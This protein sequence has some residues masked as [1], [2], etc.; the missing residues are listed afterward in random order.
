MSEHRQ[1]RCIEPPRRVTGG[2]RHEL[3]VKAELIQE[4]TQPR[5]IMGGETVMRAEW[6]G[7]FGER[8]AK[9][10]RHHILVRHVVW[11]FAQPVHVVGERDQ[12]CLYL[13]IGEDTKGMAHHGGARDFAECTDM[14][15]AGGAVAGLE[16]QLVFRLLLQARN[17]LARLLERP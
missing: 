12:P 7:Y 9:M 1:Q 11:D 10:P 14:R 6:V 3:V 4:S 15:Q 13:V 16:D 17:E 2:C 5:I 8:L